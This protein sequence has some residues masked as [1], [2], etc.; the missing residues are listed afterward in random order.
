MKAPIRAGLAGATVVLF[1]ASAEGTALADDV[2]DD[3]IEHTIIVGLVSVLAP[4]L[5]SGDGVQPCGLRWQS[6]LQGLD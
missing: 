3:D 1:V 4:S 6:R 2:A 5:G